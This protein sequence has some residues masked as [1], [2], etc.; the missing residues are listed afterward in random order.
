MLIFFR[1]KFVL[2]FGGLVVWLFGGLV[3]LWFG[4]L[5]V[6]LFCCFVV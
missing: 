5:V 3:V 1:K 4:G 6:W 2:W